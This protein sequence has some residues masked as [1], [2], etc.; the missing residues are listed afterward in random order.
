MAYELTID[1][2]DGKADDVAAVV[3]QFASVPGTEIPSDENV[4]LR[5]KNPNG[6]CPVSAPDTS[7]LVPSGVRTTAL[8]ISFICCMPYGN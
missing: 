7:A 6:L 2:A 8:L 3:V 4:V 1:H 5:N